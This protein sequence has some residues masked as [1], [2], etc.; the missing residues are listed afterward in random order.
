MV[1]TSS[2][3]GKSGVHIKLSMGFPESD[4]PVNRT[5]L[6]TDDPMSEDSRS[7]VNA[8]GTDMIN[9]GL[10]RWR[11]AVESGKEELSPV[12]RHGIDPGC[13]E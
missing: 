4:A 13:G 6:R 8:I 11:I 3:C 9:P 12:R 2:G 10:I 5:A 7:I 1:R